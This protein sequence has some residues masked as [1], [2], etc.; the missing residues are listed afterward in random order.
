MIDAWEKKKKHYMALNIAKNMYEVCL[1]FKE[2]LLFKIVTNKLYQEGI[3]IFKYNIKLQLMNLNIYC[4]A[5]GKNG[6][7]QE[8]SLCTL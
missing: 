6:I 2:L 7:F 8:E 3:I 5:K 4:M 1:G